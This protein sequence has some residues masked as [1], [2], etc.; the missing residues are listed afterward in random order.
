MFGLMSLLSG[1]T[2]CAYFAIIPVK[3]LTRESVLFSEF[4]HCLYYRIFVND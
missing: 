4:V 1:H 2:N 3:N